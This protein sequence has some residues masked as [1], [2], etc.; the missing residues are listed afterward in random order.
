MLQARGDGIPRKKLREAAR[1][2]STPRPDPAE[3][4]ALGLTIDDYNAEPAVVVYAEN[5]DTVSVFSAMGTQWRTG[6][7]GPTGLDYG[8]LW[9]VMR[10]VGVM[11]RKAQDEVFLGVRIME[12]ES[13][14]CFRERAQ[15]R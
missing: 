11:R 10:A 4:N 14:T 9:Q 7:S 3:L 8:P 2:L 6:M 13:L 5:W 15:N 12:V 1:A